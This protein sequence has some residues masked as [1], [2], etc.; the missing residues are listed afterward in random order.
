[1]KVDPT[2][3][4]ETA[5]IAF[6][7]VLLSLLTESVFLILGKWDFKVLFGNLLSG[8]AA[9]LNFFLLGLT[10]QR[11]VQK[12][13]KEAKTVLRFSQ[14]YRTIGLLICGGVGVYFFN[15]VTALLP[16]FFPRIAILFRPI[17][18]KRGDRDA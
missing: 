3:K 15:P 18:N 5:Y 16:L 9:V 14:T 2:V 11:A 4:K 6:F 13:E 7:T 17:L 1:M 10:V 8:C 12:D